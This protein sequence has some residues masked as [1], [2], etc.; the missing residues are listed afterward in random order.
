MIIDVT[1]NRGGDIK[2][3]LNIINLLLNNISTIC[4]IKNAK[5][6]KT[7]LISEGIGTCINIVILVN[8]YTSSAAELLVSA[9]KSNGGIIIGKKTYG[10][11]TI[12]S[13]LPLTEYDGSALK[14]TV[15][16]FYTPNNEK[17]NGV[18]IRP[19]YEMDINNL[20]DSNMNDIISFV[21][22]VFK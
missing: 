5:S 12:Q 11:S 16:E 2:Q 10:K 20:L 13:I 18:G 8:E 7:K 4:V 6:A 9:I 17:I 15:S 1:N 3:C 19:N 21:K 14:I 22:S